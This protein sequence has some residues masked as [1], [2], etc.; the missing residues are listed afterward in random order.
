MEVSG[1]DYDRVS[2]DSVARIAEMTYYNVTEEFGYGGNY[3]P[4]LKAGE[5]IQVNMAWIVNEDV[6]EKMYLNLSG[7]FGTYEFTESMLDVGVVDI[8]Q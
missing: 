8:C 1:L 5:S 4:S 2:E 6:L 3:I 7:D